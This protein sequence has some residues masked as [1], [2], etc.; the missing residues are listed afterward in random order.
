M[1]FRISGAAIRNPIPPLVL[2][3]VLTLLGL[4]SF[5]MLPITRAPN[6]DVPIVAVTVLQPGAA[7]AELETQVTKRVE[8]AVAAITGVKHV[9][10]TVTDGT[11]LTVIELRLEV[12]SDRALNDVLDALAKIRSLLPRDIDEP[13][14][15][16]CWPARVT[17]AANVATAAS[18]PPAI[19]GVPAARPRRCAA[20]RVSVPTVSLERTRRSGSM[21]RSR[22]SAVHVSCDQV[23]RS[24][25]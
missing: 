11:S 6:I 17:P 12:S 14:I 19:T 10:S 24:R 23:A 3:A 22:P 8:D 4:V 2:F 20:S 7:P 16:T 25:S 1:A 15:A 13:I 9:L 5:N 21:R 18:T